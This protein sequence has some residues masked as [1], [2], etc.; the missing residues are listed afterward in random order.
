MPMSAEC[1]WLASECQLSSSPAKKEEKEVT[2]VGQ[3]EPILGAQL[4]QTWRCME[5]YRKE[6]FSGKEI[7][8]K[9]KLSRLTSQPV[10]LDGRNVLKDVSPQVDDK[11]DH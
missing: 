7:M 8:K 1:R 2:E 4:F 9:K 6:E 11:N 5:G 3:L 10:H